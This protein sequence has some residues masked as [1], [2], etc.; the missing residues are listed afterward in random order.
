MATVSV[1]SF[2]VRGIRNRQKRRTIFRHLHVKYPNHII[3]IQETHSSIDIEQQWKN[4]WGSSLFFSHGSTF[5]AG[6]AILLPK[7]FAWSIQG[8]M[9]DKEGRVIGIQFSMEKEMFSII[10]IYGPA[11]DVQEQKLDFF[12]KLR[13]KLVSFTSVNTILCGDFNVHLGP[14][15]V[16]M[17]KYKPTAASKCIFELIE[18]FSLKDIWRFQNP[19]KR[20]YTW[21]RKTPLQQSK[22]DYAFSSEAIC[23][24]FDVHSFIEA[25][26]KS[27]HSVIVI[28]A[29][30]ARRKRGPGLYRFN[31][32][33]LNDT[34]FV[35]LAKTEI[36]QANN[37]VGIYNG[38]IDYGVKIEMLLSNIRVISIRRSKTI[39]YKMRREECELLQQVTE[40]ERDLRSLDDNQK[41]NYGISRQKLDEI[42]TIRAKRA[43]IASGA[44][45][46]EEGEKATAYFLSRGKQL[47]AQKTINEIK[48][49]DQ[50]I[51][52]GNEILEYCAKYYEQV[53]ESKGIDRPVMNCF[54]SCEQIPKLSEEE[55]EQCEG[56]ILSEE[57]RAA[58]MRMNRNKAPGI[59]G[60]TAEFFLHFLGRYWRYNNRVFKSR[61]YSRLLHISKTGSSDSDSQ[62][63][64]SRQD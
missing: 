49:N 13:H 14:Y 46:I 62:K 30:S 56:P 6:V 59:S 19:V 58:L 18:Q 36:Y 38:D 41:I 48:E 28:T 20:E 9:S 5:Q 16:E 31:N 51:T 10:G 27:D 61:I 43:I 53:F 23:C 25:G 4:E 60:F 15:D 42:K 21:R 34:E 64:R 45:W 57:C 52:N 50:V 2:N 39:A 63:R 1:V 12:E 37:R 7:N 32:E 8:N 44:K 55:R 11:T 29:V 3:C 17:G 35:E 22:I 33:L 40:F 26:V 24:N 54:L 47:S